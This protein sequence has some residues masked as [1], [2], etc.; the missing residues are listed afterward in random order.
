MKLLDLLHH[1]VKIECDNG[2]IIEGYV[3]MHT[4]AEDNEPEPESIGIQNYEL[5]EADIKKVTVLD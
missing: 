5:F 4:S 1:N 3:H 2:L